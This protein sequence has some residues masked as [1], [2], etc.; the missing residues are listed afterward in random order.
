MADTI[1]VDVDSAVAEVAN[2][3]NMI[4]LVTAVAGLLSVLYL[5]QLL[6]GGPKKTLPLEDVAAATDMA[7]AFAAAGCDEFVHAGGYADAS[8]YRDRI[9]LLSEQIIPAVA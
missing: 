2:N 8:A 4:I 3:N 6:F 1:E 5:V 7:R 9:D